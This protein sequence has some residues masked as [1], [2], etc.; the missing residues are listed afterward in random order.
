MLAPILLGMSRADGV[1]GTVAVDCLALAVATSPPDDLTVVKRFPISEF[2]ISV[3]EL[4]SPFAEEI[5]DQLL[6]RHASLGATLVVSLDL[7]EF[8]GRSRDG[9]QPGSEEQGALLEDLGSFKSQ[10]MSRPSSEL[11]LIEGGRRLSAVG[12]ADGVLSR[13]EQP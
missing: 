6:L 10:L 13:R 1:P 4:S 5:P 7:Y 11:V 2:E 8:L 12:L 9:L 3:P